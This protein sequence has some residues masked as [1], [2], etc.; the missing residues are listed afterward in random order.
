VSV[1]GSLI[2][3]DVLEEG[4]RL[5]SVLEAEGIPVRLLGGLG[6]RLVAVDAY[7]PELARQYN[8]IDLVTGS[9][10]GR[11]LAQTLIAQGYQPNEMFNR[12][13]GARR[14]LFYDEPNGR[15]LDVFVGSFEM[16]HTL[17]IAERL[18][19]VPLTLPAAD[20]LLTKLQIVKLNEKDRND[21]YA[22]LIALDVGSIDDG[23]I[24]A[25]WIA[26][27]CARDWG[28]FRT[29]QLNLE[30][31][32]EGV[33]GVPVSADGRDLIVRRL[34]ALERALEDE[35]KGSKWK[36]RARVGDKVRWYDDPEEVERHGY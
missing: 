1:N 17:P 12:M 11:R 20:L 3:P 23:A 21:V 36:L 15:Q 33:G 10:N 25:A 7:P 27:L 22:L 19:V 18:D 30:K 13:H 26:R 28:L 16:C 35:P 31:L 14:L 24:N 4:R 29:L 5:S 8:D 32:R 6:I 2:Q 9:R 34:D